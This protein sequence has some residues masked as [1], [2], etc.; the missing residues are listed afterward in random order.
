[1]M[2]L[3]VFSNL[4]DSM[5]LF[6]L[7]ILSNLFEMDSSQKQLQKNQKGHNVNW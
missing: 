2:I 7:Q 1:L 3:E 5:I 4:N 6:V